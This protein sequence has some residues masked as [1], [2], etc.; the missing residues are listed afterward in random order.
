MFQSTSAILGRSSK[1][2][3][4][5]QWMSS[6]DTCTY[7]FLSF[8][9]RFSNLTLTFMAIIMRLALLMRRFWGF[10][11]RWRTFLLWQKARPLS[12]WYMS[13]WTFSL[14][15]S[16][17]RLSKYFLRSWSQCSKTKVSFLSEC[18]TSCRRT[19]FRC[20]SSF[21]RHISLNADEGTPLNKNS[22]LMIL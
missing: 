14:S 8:F 21:S 19:M 17:L 3:L 16:P 12:S 4:T 10:K 22:L 9:S 1:S 15:I 18:N 20:F 7:N 5:S 2:F 6:E 11:S 13:D